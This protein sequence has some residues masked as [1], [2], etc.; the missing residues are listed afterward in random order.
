MVT[1]LIF[2]GPGTIQKGTEESG[3]WQSCGMTWCHQLLEIHLPSPKLWALQR[4][5]M[6]VVL[7]VEGPGGD[8][9]GL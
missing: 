7:E 4:N 8:S 3:S 6:T 5:S 2:A 9:P 1:G